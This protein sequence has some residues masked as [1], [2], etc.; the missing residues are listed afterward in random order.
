M[1]ERGRFHWIHFA[2]VDFLVTLYC[3]CIC[4]LHKK[5]L[6]CFVICVHLNIRNIIHY[7][8]SQLI[9]CVPISSRI[10]VVKNKA[11]DHTR[12][13]TH[14][15]DRGPRRTSVRVGNTGCASNVTTPG[16]FFY[17]VYFIGLNFRHTIMRSLAFARVLFWYLGY[18]HVRTLMIGLGIAKQFI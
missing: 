12:V 17:I 16:Q 4:C 3:L 8:R 5:E 11:Y 18:L 6:W 9:E 10:I 15:K 13:S 14:I 1:I 2:C 7:K